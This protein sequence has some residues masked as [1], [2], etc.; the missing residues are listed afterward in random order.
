MVPIRLDVREDRPSNYKIE[1][2]STKLTHLF[3]SFMEA[4][5]KHTVE[6]L[7]A[8]SNTRTPS[9]PWVH[10]VRLLVP[11]SCCDE[12]ATHLIKALGGEEITKRVV[13][14]TKWWQVRGVKGVDAEWIV[15]KKDYQEAKRKQKAR[16]MSMDASSPGPQ[17]GENPNQEI[18][19]SYQPEMDEMRCILYA[20]GGGYYFGSFDQE[21]YS[22]QRL[23]R[24]INGRVFTMNYRLA[25]QYPFPCAIQDFIASYLYLIQPP[26]GALHTPV[27]PSNIVF[28][29]DSA[30][31]GL[32]IAGLQVVRDAGL[33]LP[34]AAVL[35]SPWCDLTHSFPSVHLNTATD[36]IPQ[37]GLSFHKP[38]TLWPPP[39]DHVTKRVHQ[40]LR[41]RV[42]QAVRFKGK[43]KGTGVPV[44]DPVL[45]L[46][47]PADLPSRPATPDYNISDPTS[48][49]TLHLGAAKTIQ[50]PVLPGT[51]KSQRLELTTCRGETLAIEGQ[52][53]MYAPN[54]LLAHPLVSPVVS[55]LG[56]LPPLLVI[57]SDKEVLRDEI[58]YFAHK[59]AN[60]EKYPI[61]PESKLLYP[62]LEGIEERYGP[63][64]VHLQVYDDCAHTLPILFAFTT[65]GKFCFR[66][67]ATFVKYVTG[68]LP[69]PRA[70]MPRILENEDNKEMRVTQSPAST[71]MDLLNLN[72]GPPRM[73]TSRSEPL[74]N[75]KRS[76]QTVSATPVDNPSSPAAGVSSS[77]TSGVP[78]VSV[79]S[80]ST[81]G[82]TRRALSASVTRASSFLRRRHAASESDVSP[83][84]GT[85]PPR[86]RGQ[87]SSGSSDVAGPRWQYHK[88]TADPQLRHAGEQE[89]YDNGLDAMIRE[90]VSTHGVLRP[91]E[92]EPEL[93]AFRLPPELIGEISE[94]TVRRYMD[95]TA[96][97][98]KKF[99]KTSQAIEKARERNLE[100]AKQDTMRNMVQLQTFLAHEHDE[101]GKGKQRGIGEAEGGATVKAGLA[102]SGSWQWAWALD[103]DENPPPSSIVS[104]RDTEE[105]RRLAKIADQAVF[106]EDQAISG[107]NLWQLIVN[108]LTVTPDR[109][110]HK[111][112][113][114][115][116]HQHA[117][118][119]KSK[120]KPE[121]DG[122]PVRVAGTG[123]P[124]EKPASVGAK[125]AEKPETMSRREKI[126]SKFAW[127]VAENRKSRGAA[128]T[129]PNEQ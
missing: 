72:G 40:G 15:A 123:E 125:V 102:A 16:R 29:G 37:F 117:V 6:E 27:S 47:Q 127:L 107:N 44:P 68:M 70:E 18:P 46:E 17:D 67:M 63:T 81:P 85:P 32:C 22:I 48:G 19:P 8:F 84:P 97:F 110:A 36:I 13:G 82:K 126:V 41:E 25:P 100:C 76:I 106:S 65:P 122:A 109:D 71:Q 21:R 86:S 92:P 52:V 1:S 95:G 98:G 108:F 4:A 60:P 2:K 56:G 51:V 64:K 105:A 91:L 39:P 119:E 26:P 114:H 30:G 69:K 59:A 42:R 5:T 90:R 43:D 55:Y 20:H 120:Q 7:Q 73:A 45:D 75:T 54:F 58:I 74:M 128:A 104:R 113:G 66:A 118:S 33:P 121:G 9:P 62:P 103:V 50:S 77:S 116:Q 57:A 23:A 115:H 3:Q 12:A 28:A 38:S 31:G 35:I 111:H 79:S 24:K 96:K 34:G 129:A 87:D 89:V 112:H 88:S 93:S 53:H 49:R 99:S 94:L 11:M 61:K 83:V 80:T 101:H 78:P 14:G 10:V 124:S